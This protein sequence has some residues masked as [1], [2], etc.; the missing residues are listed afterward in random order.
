MLI[1]LNCNNEELASTF[2]VARS[3]VV[4]AKYRIRKKL[5]LEEGTSMEEYLSRALQ[6]GQ[7]SDFS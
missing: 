2:N 6:E 5:N 1:A 7:E 3:S 4:V